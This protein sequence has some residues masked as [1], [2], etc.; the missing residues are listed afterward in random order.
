VV[1]LTNDANGYVIA[2]AVRIEQLTMGPEVIDDGGAGFFATDGFTSFSGQG[3]GGDV[4][5]AAPGAGEQIAGWTFTVTPGVYRISATWSEDPN[6]ATNAPFHIYDGSTFLGEVRMNQELAPDDF[7]EDG[8]W[9]EDLGDGVFRITG[10]ELSVFLLDSADEYVIA[11]AVRIE[12]I[13]A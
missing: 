1:R 12:R 8:T 7:R 5:F 10:T 11:D 9:W 4:T 13:G 3:H 6:R 2:D